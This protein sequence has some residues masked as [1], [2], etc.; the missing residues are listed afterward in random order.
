[1][2]CGPRRGV[3]PG[4][5]V[6]GE[7]EGIFLFEVS[8]GVYMGSSRRPK[9]SKAW[10]G[11]TSTVEKIVDNAQRGS[12][13]TDGDMLTD[14]RFPY[15]CSLRQD[16]LAAVMITTPRSVRLSETRFCLFPAPLHLHDRS[17]L[18]RDG[19]STCARGRRSAQP[20]I[21]DGASKLWWP[22]LKVHRKFH[23]KPT[24]LLI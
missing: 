11:T 13:V 4:R 22:N 6:V 9:P 2:C 8:P 12:G 15:A 7:R 14:S 19:R 20:D 16:P 23:Q 10:R 1:M 21:A 17:V 18:S 24:G 5:R 3:E